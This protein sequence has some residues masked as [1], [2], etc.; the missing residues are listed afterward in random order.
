MIINDLGFSVKND[1]SEQL[2]KLFSAQLHVS[3]NFLKKPRPK[4]FPR[5]NGNNR[6]PAI[7]MAEKMMTAFGS[8]HGKSNFEK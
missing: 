4:R 3:K 7:C 5:M 1:G 2:A 6:G 8:A